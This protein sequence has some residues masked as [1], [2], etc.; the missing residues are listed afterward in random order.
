MYDLTD[1]FQLSDLAAR[2][3]IHKKRAYLLRLQ[4]FEVIANRAMIFI[5]L[6]HSS[7][8]CKKVSTHGLQTTFLF[9]SNI[10]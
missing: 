5:Y 4:K 1:L 9:M 6:F 7:L 10:T 8:S 2:T 3:N